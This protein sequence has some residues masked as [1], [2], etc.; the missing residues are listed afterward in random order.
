MATDVGWTEFH[1]YFDDG[2]R[3]CCYPN[4]NNFFAVRLAVFD[5]GRSPSGK[6]DSF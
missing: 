5:S 4:A 2:L 3:Q 1:T 6:D